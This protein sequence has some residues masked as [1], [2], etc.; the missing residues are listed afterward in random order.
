M[1]WLRRWQS[2]TR[3]LR[4][5]EASGRTTA[6]D[7]DAI[8]IPTSDKREINRLDF[9]HY[10]LRQALQGNYVAPIG[11]PQ[12]ILD[13][14]CGTGRWAYELSLRFPQADVVGFDRDL[15]AAHAA[16]SPAA[17]GTSAL[18]CRFVQGDVL[19]GL[20]FA[21]E[22]F[23]FVHMR[24]LFLSLPAQRWPAVVRELARVTRRGGWIEVIETT[25]PRQVGPS[26]D[27]ICRWCVRLA[28]VHGIDLYAAEQL[29]AYLRDAQVSGVV[30]TRMLLPLGPHGGRIGMM[31]A[32]D[33]FAYIEGFRPAILRDGIATAQ[34]YAQAMQDAQRE[35]SAGKS[36]QPFYIA[37]GQRV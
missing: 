5:E 28:M 27:L 24:L 13:V 22:S 32:A 23:D 18:R 31:V 7:A 35:L 25:P 20:P 12:R 14:G 33:D 30:S 19:Q 11:R 21:D 16:I 6:D 8:L 2:T 29:D 4:R 17:F 10:L 37:Y 3:G 36:V 26:L 15:T 9:E 1:D 34:A